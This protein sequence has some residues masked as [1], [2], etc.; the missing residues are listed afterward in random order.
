MKLLK[1]TVAAVTLATSTITPAAIFEV[2][3]YEINARIAINTTSESTL[4]LNDSFGIGY[5]N[6]ISELGGS[7]YW[8]AGQ[9]GEYI[10]FNF[11]DYVTSSTDPLNGDF[12]ANGGRVDFWL[13]SSDLYS[14][15]VDYFTSKAI[16]E[17]G[18]LL[19]GATG[20]GTTEGTNFNNGYR[21]NGFL[22]IISG[23]ELLAINTNQSINLVGGDA[24]LSFNITGSHFNNDNYDFVGSSDGIGVS[25]VPAPAP[26]ALMGTSLISLGLVRRKKA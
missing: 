16:Q 12:V 17:A 9:N 3:N 24:D 7:T 14:T 6:S 21:A 23:T 25:A 1:Y 22:D 5:V 19:I 15:A 11:S 26:L 10:N 2:G 18:T 13:N 20:S 4:G 8:A